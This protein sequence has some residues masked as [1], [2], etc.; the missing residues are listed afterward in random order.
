[1]RAAQIAAVSGRLVWSA[2]APA[3]AP[4]DPARNIETLT[5]L[6]IVI[7]IVVMGIYPQPFIAKI[8]PSAERQMAVIEKVQQIADYRIDSLKPGQELKTGD[9]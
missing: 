8:E 9:Q 3:E 4:P 1:M 2:C 5:I 7:L 6:P